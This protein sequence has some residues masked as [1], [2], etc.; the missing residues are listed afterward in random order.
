MYYFVRDCLFPAGFFF[1][2]DISFIFQ[3]YTDKYQKYLLITLYLLHVMLDICQSKSDM[4][5]FCFYRNLNY[6]LLFA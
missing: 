2:G 3:C 5:L 4:N 6:P 1:N